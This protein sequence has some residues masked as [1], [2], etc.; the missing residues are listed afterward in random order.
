MCRRVQH[1][2][3]SPHTSSYLRPSASI[4]GLILQIPDNLSDPFCCRRANSWTQI[5]AEA[6]CEAA[7]ERARADAAVEQL[8]AVG[9][10]QEA[11]TSEYAADAAGATGQDEVTPPPIAAA[12]A[13]ADEPAAQTAGLP[14]AKVPAVATAAVPAVGRLLQDVQ[15]DTLAA[16]TREAP[17]GPNVLGAAP[18]AAGAGPDQQS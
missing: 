13:A 1:I 15:A 6:R 4:P 16:L 5:L 8:E 3:H 14:A 9:R 11:A 17:A 10:Q 18:A 2:V 7:A 12:S